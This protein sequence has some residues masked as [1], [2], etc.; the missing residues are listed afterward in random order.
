[1]NK[2]LKNKLDIV[3]SKYI[4]L[5]DL[6][7]DGKTFTCISCGRIKPAEQMDCGHYINRMHTSVRWNEANAHGECRHCNRFDENHLKGYRDNLV[8]KIG[9]DKV[10]LLEAMKWKQTKMADFEMEVAIKYYKDKIEQME[11]KK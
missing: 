4:R 11:K 3:F 2:T 9:E 8:K 7:S 1:M 5:R 6:N 10:L